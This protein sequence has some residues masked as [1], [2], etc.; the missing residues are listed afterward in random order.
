M[1]SSHILLRRLAVT[2]HPHAN[3][4]PTD[5]STRSWGTPDKKRSGGRQQ[6]EGEDEL[7]FDS[8]RDRGMEQSVYVFDVHLCLGVLSSTSCTG[9]PCPN[10]DLFG[11]LGRWKRFSFVSPKSHRKTGFPMVLDYLVSGPYLLADES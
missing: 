8:T 5:I 3:V 4:V 11:R 9:P 1:K 6:L 2:R 10:Q 7:G